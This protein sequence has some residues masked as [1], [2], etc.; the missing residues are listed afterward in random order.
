MCF[1]SISY[2]WRRTSEELEEGET[3]L[4]YSSFY[5]R[6]QFQVRASMPSSIRKV[7]HYFWRLLKINGRKGAKPGTL[8][9]LR[10]R[11]PCQVT[12]RLSDLKGEDLPSSKLAKASAVHEEI[13]RWGRSR[14]P[15]EILRLI[16]KHA[17]ALGLHKDGDLESANRFPYLVSDACYQL[18]EV[19]SDFPAAWTRVCVYLEDED[20]AATLRTYL[21]RS[22]DLFL[23]D[24][25]ITRRD[26]TSINARPKSECEK[27][28]CDPLEAEKVRALLPLLYEN[29]WR[30]RNLTIRTMSGN[31][32][33][34][35]LDFFLIGQG[36]RSSL[37]VRLQS[38]VQRPTGCGSK[39]I[40][41]SP[42]F[43]SP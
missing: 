9:R 20:P 2:E 4:R 27:V 6:H 26:W 40:S 42:S 19:L 35:V 31:S 1:T 43:G 36:N 14:F 7:P 8:T 21:E 17:I 39:L 28:R 10:I 24:I 15:P 13:Q 18:D 22:E 29:A 16:F 38:I 30:C 23:E 25:L 3:A 32:L 33:P 12:D 37:I 41:P 5:H 11:S 34:R